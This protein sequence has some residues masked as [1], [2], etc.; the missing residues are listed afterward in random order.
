MKGQIFHVYLSK[1][2]SQN[3]PAIKEIVMKLNWK[4]LTISMENLF[5]VGFKSWKCRPSQI[6]C[7]TVCCLVIIKV[8][9]VDSTLEMKR[10]R[11]LILTY[12][13]ITL[14]YSVNFD[15]LHSDQT[16]FTLFK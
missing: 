14:Q 15:F 8:K 13:M 4:I 6:Y 1:T 12:S 7:L 9:T 2:S 3:K 11:Y 10:N 5:P 16:K